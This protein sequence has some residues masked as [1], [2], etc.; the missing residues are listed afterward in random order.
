MGNHLLAACAALGLALPAGAADVDGSVRVQATDGGQVAGA[1]P[2]VVYL[3]GFRQPPPPE[4][5]VIAQKDKTFIPSLRV[6]VA[7]QSVQFTNEDPVVHNVFSTS[8]A[9]TFDLGKPGPQQAREINFPTPGLVDV[10]CNI[11]E[12]MFANV[13]VLPNRATSYRFL[14]RAI[15]LIGALTLLLVAAPVILVLA[16]LIRVDSPGPAIFRQTRITRGGRTFRFYKFRT[17][18]VDA[19]ERFPELYAYDFSDGDFDSS[20]YKLADDPRNTR[21]GR[22]LRRTTLDELP[23]LFNVLKGDLSLVGPRPE[24]PELVRYY[25]PEELACLFTKAGLTGLAQ[26]AGRS[27]LTVRERLTLDTRYVANQGTLLDLRILFRTVVVV[28]TG[29]GAF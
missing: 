16:A 7:G 3:T 9:R 20:Y 22:W 5:P 6:I 12:A 29:K 10:Y 11:H 13:L 19:K 14:K 28:L 17:M 8:A 2:I 23:N 26:V 25:R 24:L 15:D 18:Y 21:V 1:Q 27:L 4:V